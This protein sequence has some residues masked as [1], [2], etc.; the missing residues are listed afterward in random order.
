[1]QPRPTGVQLLLHIEG[2]A[3][4][5]IQQAAQQARRWQRA[6]ARAQSNALLLNLLI[7]SFLVEPFALC[8]SSKWTQK[9]LSAACCEVHD[10][11]CDRARSNALL[12]K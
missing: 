12:L 6:G 3:L 2:L 8:D 5:P 10:N 1:M 7:R 4:V 9:G 11:Y